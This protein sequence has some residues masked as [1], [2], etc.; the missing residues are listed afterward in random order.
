MLANAGFVTGSEA[1]SPDVW[2]LS[3]ARRLVV[4]VAAFAFVLQSYVVQTHIHGLLARVGGA[5]GVTTQHAPG[6]E[7]SPFDHGSADCPLCQAVI[8]AGAFVAPAAPL[9]HLPFTWTNAA[10][11][12]FTA[13]ATS[14][15]SAHDWQSRA[16][17]RF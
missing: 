7:K 4:L 1:K 14:A 13:V 9:L 6:A 12:V 16:P 15:A 2:R 10:A 8:H 11:V 3:L 17:P 5:V